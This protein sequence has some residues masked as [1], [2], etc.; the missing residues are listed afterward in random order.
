MLIDINTSVIQPLFMASIEQK[1]TRKWA[2]TEWTI[3]TNT[4]LGEPKQMVMGW[5]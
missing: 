4:E 5:E 3:E 1:E 2:D